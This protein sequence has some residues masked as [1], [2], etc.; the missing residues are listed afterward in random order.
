MG[1][2][3]LGHFLCQDNDEK[4]VFFFNI[5][6]LTALSVY[7]VLIQNFLHSFFPLGIALQI[8]HKRDL[9]NSEIVVCGFFMR[10]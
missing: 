5:E 7:Y 10:T 1:E 2:K 9:K 4:L 3:N 6:I 8:I